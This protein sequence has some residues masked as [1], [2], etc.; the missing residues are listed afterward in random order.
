MNENKK[1]TLKIMDISL[2]ESNM[3]EKVSESIK[4]LK[5]QGFEKIKLTL[6]GSFE[7]KLKKSGYSPDLFNRIKFKQDLPDSVVYDLI[8]SCG[9]LKGT[10]FESRLKDGE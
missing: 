5:D 6:E 3:I 1:N 4:E 8:E 7:D 10:D 9:K 2:D